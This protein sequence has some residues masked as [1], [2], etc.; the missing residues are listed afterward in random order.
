MHNKIYNIKNEREASD[1]TEESQIKLSGKHNLMSKSFGDFTKEW[2]I[3][4]NIFAQVKIQSN[5]LIESKQHE[6]FYL[7]IA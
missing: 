3:A 6:I 5:C 7:I 1:T 2:K 4:E